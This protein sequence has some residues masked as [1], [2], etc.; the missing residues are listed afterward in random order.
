MNNENFKSSVLE[1]GNIVTEIIVFSG[2]NKKTFKGVITKSIHQSEFARFDLT[3]GRRIYINPNNVDCFEVL[4]EN[5]SEN[6]EEEIK[7]NIQTK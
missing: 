5:I 6:F 1:K 2:G 3:D 4:P 7:S